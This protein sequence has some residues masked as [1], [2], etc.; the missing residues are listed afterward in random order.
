M[1]P[2]GHGEGPR[3]RHKNG[4]KVKHMHSDFDSLWQHRPSDKVVRKFR[5]EIDKVGL[6]LW[7]FS[8]SV[9]YSFKNPQDN[10]VAELAILKTTTAANSLLI[11][12]MLH[13]SFWELGFSLAV[14]ILTNCIAEIRQF[15]FSLLSKKYGEDALIISNLK[16]PILF[17]FF[18]L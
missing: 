5:N 9:T 11:N 17:S 15:N 8:I 1:G 6:E 16:Y 12:K 3:A 4:W 10:Q 13:G 7:K 14:R 2:E 18:E